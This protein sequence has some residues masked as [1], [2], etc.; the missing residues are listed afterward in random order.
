MWAPNDRSRH[1]PMNSPRQ[2]A[3]QFGA[4]CCVLWALSCGARAQLATSVLTVTGIKV[5]RLTNAIQV[6]IETDGTPQFGTD[7]AEFIDFSGFGPKPTQ[8]LRIRVVGARARLP[9]F[10]PLDAYPLDGA[11]ITPG[12][13]DFANPYFSRGA[14]EQPQPRVDIEIRFA[15][16]IQVQQFSVNAGDGGIQFGRYANPLQVTVEPST[17]GRAILLTVFPDRADLGGPARLDRSPASERN[18][19]LAFGKRRDG[20]F[21]VWA[22]HAPLRQVLAGLGEITG[23]RFL[24]REEVADLEVTLFLPAATRAQL[25]EVLQNGYNLGLIEDRGTLILGRGDEFLQAR[26]F[27]LGNLSPDAARLLFPDFLLPFL[28]PDRQANALVAT[29][30]PAVLRRIAA[31]L[32]TLDQPR[33]QFEIEAQVWELSATR[34]LNFALQLARSVGRDRQ[35]LDLATGNTS[36]IV[37]SGQTDQLLARLNALAQNGRG[38]LRATPRVTVLAGESGRLFVGQTRYIL[39][40]QQRGNQQ[41]SQALPLQIGANLEVTAR[42]TL[43]PGD[44]ISL[45]VAPRVSTVDALEKATGLPT[46]GIREA[47]ATLRVQGGQS[48]IVAGL[49]STLDFSTQGRT[50]KILPSRRANREQQQLLILVKARRIRSADPQMP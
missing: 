30:T 25:L 46:I 3:A 1:Q 47:S 34:D 23:A 6:R 11:V 31:D 41:V 50:L 32:K 21:R 40:L 29:G 43:R 2:L 48:V 9:G 17:D 45:Q 12:N 19:G 37:E 49:D 22:L 38:R 8:S 4:L 35:T 16:P 27:A 33:A 7:L 13:S 39:V 26:Q 15:T 28:R 10:V 5:K 24:A 42:G 14:S 36:L 18:R 20:T 44:P